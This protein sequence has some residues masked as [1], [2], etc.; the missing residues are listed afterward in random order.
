MAERITLA[1]AMEKATRTMWPRPVRRE[2]YRRATVN[3]VHVLILFYS[4][5]YDWGREYRYEV[6]EGLRSQGGGV[7]G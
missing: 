3:G 1:A 4:C 5:N 6:F 7:I 2:S